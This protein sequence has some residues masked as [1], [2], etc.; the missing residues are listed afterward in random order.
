MNSSFR[1]IKDLAGRATTN[2]L[3]GARPLA[4]AV[5][6]ESIQR[7]ITDICNWLTPTQ[8]S[9]VLGKVVEHLRENY[10]PRPSLIL[11]RVLPLSQDLREYIQWNSVITRSI[12]GPWIRPAIYPGRLI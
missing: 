4:S 6:P 12:W 7:R 10:P 5:V 9:Q 8:T 1:N 2:F 3:S 11:E